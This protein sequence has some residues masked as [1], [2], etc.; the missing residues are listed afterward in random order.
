M[1]NTILLH[2]AVPIIVVGLIGHIIA[3]LII[4]ARKRKWE[5][6]IFEKNKQIMEYE[7]KAQKNENL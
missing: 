6:K 1:I 3:R 4:K 7:K 2:V 5:K